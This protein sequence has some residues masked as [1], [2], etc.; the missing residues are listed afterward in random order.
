MASERSAGS[1]VATPWGDVVVEA[2]ATADPAGIE[3][4]LFSAGGARSKE[5]APRFAAAGA[6]VVDNSSAWR[7]D[8]KVPLVVVGVNDAAARGHHGIIANPNCTTMVMLM[9]R[10][11]AASSRRA[12]ANWWPPRTRRCPGPGRRASPPCSTRAAHFAGDPEALRTG[13]W[14]EPPPG[15]YVRPIGFNV[16]PFAGTAAEAGY[17][18]EEWKLVNE[19]RKILDAPEALGRADLRAGAGDGGPRDRG[20]RWFGRP[21]G[22][23]RR[24]VSSEPPRA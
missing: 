5:H 13:T 15:F 20:D 12:A 10:G 24:A 1:A 11:A 18:D 14:T 7:M 23:R 8:P 19:T 21:L 9:V 3:V 6:V 2:L 4:A 22:W 17:T 16:I